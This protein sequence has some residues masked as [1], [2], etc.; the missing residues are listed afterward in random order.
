MNAAKEQSHSTERLQDHSKA[1]PSD[2]ADRALDSDSSFDR[3]LNLT[4]AAKLAPGRP[5]TNCM[6]RWCRKGVLARSGDRVRLQHIRMG[7]KLYTTSQWVQEF[8]R[9]LAEADARYFDRAAP[10]R[11]S[12]PPTCHP[13]Q[14]RQPLRKTVDLE[15]IERELAEAGI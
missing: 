2:G 1:R 6:W 5:S 11:V 10:E 9:R 8:G 4:E 13:R 7:G 12:E 3:P 15:A 14:E